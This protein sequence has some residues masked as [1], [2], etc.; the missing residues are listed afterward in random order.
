MAMQIMPGKCSDKVI[1][2]DE[3]CSQINLTETLRNICE[4]Y[5]IEENFQEGEEEITLSVLRYDDMSLFSRRIENEICSLL[6]KIR[7][8]SGDI[9]KSELVSSV[10]DLVL[11]R[12]III[13]ALL[14]DDSKNSVLTIS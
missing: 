2:Y 14:S 9:A 11:L 12:S 8:T 7:K 4:K 3:T 13:E 5:F 6:D 10:K 1:T